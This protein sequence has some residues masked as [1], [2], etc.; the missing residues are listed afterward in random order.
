MSAI[1]TDTARS[2]STGAAG[3]NP[4][5]AATSDA[6]P[7]VVTESSAD[8]G[9]TF[10]APGSTKAIARELTD[11]STD[12]AGEGLSAAAEA[13]VVGVAVGRGAGG[14]FGAVVARGLGVGRGA[15]TAATGWIDTQRPSQA[16]RTPA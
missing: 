14:G 16:I 13:L 7:L 9:A 5:S 8:D 2:A 15:A 3:P 1:R 12:G 4:R 6:P 10:D 11:G